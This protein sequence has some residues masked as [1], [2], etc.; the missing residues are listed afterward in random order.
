MVFM[1]IILIIIVGVGA[2]HLGSYFNMSVDCSCGT[3]KERVVHLNTEQLLI[4]FLLYRIKTVRFYI[5]P[6]HERQS[7]YCERFVGLHV[8]DQNDHSIYALI[9]SEDQ[10]AIAYGNRHRLMPG[11]YCNYLETVIFETLKK[12]G[13]KA[14]FQNGINVNYSV[15]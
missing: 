14:E 1:W 10:I 13:I 11:R 3:Q 9:I 15:R 2:F 4:R 7:E 6:L 8:L 5:D 12:Y